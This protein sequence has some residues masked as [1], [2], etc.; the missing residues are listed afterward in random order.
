MPVY[1]LRYAN[2]KAIKTILEAQIYQQT[3]KYDKNAT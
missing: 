3:G 2:L 1:V